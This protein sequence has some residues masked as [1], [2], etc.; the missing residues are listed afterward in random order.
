MTW[1]Q[2]GGSVG[3][4]QSERLD[5]FEFSAKSKKSPSAMCT[6]RGKHKP[7]VGFCRRGLSAQF[8]SRTPLFEMESGSWWTCNLN[9]RNCGKVNQAQDPTALW[10]CRFPG[11]NKRGKNMWDKCLMSSKWNGPLFYWWFAEENTPFWQSCTLPWS[12]FSSI[13]VPGPRTLH[14]VLPCSLDCTKTSAC[15]FQIQK[16]GLD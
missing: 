7:S 15:V 11:K 6:Q 3:E 14:N 2:E 5:S 1:N 13:S 10:R 16:Q 12:L 4:G 9:A 8:P